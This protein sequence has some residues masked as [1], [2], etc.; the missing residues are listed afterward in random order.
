VKLM[1]EG[2]F[3]T[4]ETMIITVLAVTQTFVVEIGGIDLSQRIGASDLAVI[5][6]ALPSMRC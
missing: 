3:A 2:D 1:F 4:R 6:E 5:K